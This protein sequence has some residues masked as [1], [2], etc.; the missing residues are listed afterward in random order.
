MGWQ[1]GFGEYRGRKYYVNN[2]HAQ[3]LMDSMPDTAMHA[4]SSMGG[5]TMTILCMQHHRAITVVKNVSG[6][7]SADVFLLALETLSIFHYGEI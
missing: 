6:E 3:T 2:L 4:G 1:L 7:Y 5:S